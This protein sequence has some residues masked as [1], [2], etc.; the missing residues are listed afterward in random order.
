[1]ERRGA[2]GSNRHHGEA[3]SRM[4]HP[5]EFEVVA[6]IITTK[7]KPQTSSLSGALACDCHASEEQGSKA[8]LSG[9]RAQ[10]REGCVSGS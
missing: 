7:G 10:E 5:T 1:M 8:E 3:G 6:I 9:E 2:G 4:D